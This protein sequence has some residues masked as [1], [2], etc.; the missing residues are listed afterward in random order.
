LQRDLIN[1]FFTTIQI[2]PNP[3][4]KNTFT[5][6][7]LI[8]TLT[9]VYSQKTEL[10]ICLNTGLFSFTGN[11][12]T[13]YTQIYSAQPF[14]TGIINPYGK[15]S[16]VSGGLSLNLQRVL[17]ENIIFGMNAGYQSNQSKVLINAVAYEDLATPMVVVNAKGQS[18]VTN[19]SIMVYPFCGYRF[20]I[21]EFPIDVV[22]G[23]N[24]DF[25]SNTKEKGNATDANNTEYNGSVDIKTINLD[26]SPKIQL[27]TEYKKFGLVVGYSRGLVNYQKGNY[28]NPNYTETRE[29]YSKNINFGITYRLK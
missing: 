9:K 6:L 20:Q 25:I 29:V 1:S 7:L 11:A 4:M 26:V 24:L 28:A 23:I 16:G 17:K 15:K 10:K 27:A 19:S 22:G 14:F 5:I 18:Y 13:S 8:L 21:N 3:K 2:N 12:A